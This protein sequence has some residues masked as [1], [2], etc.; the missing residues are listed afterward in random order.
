MKIGPKYPQPFKHIMTSSPELKHQ[1]E[2]AIR[3]HQASSQAK[4]P[5]AQPKVALAQPSIKLRMDFSNFK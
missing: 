4:T 2:K 1:L 5:K 3:A